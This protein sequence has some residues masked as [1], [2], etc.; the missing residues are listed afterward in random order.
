[1]EDT[2]HL[3]P[4]PC[5]GSEVDW[6]TSRDLNVG[7]AYIQCSNINCN[8]SNIVHPFHLEYIVDGCFEDNFDFIQL[9]CVRWNKWVETKPT[10][11]KDVHW[12]V[13]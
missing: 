8:L 10:R 5:C 6:M 9:I 7:E 12:E 3:K 2:N 11:Y 4:C 13:E 1:M